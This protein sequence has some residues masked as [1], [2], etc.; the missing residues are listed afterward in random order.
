M[1]RLDIRVAAGHVHARRVGTLCADHEK[2]PPTVLHRAF[3]GSTH[4]HNRNWSKLSRGRTTKVR[5]SKMWRKQSLRIRA[6]RAA[7]HV[8]RGVE[9][10]L[11]RT[12]P[13]RSSLTAALRSA[14][15]QK[16]WL[17][18]PRIALRSSCSTAVYTLGVTNAERR[19]RLLGRRATDALGPRVRRLVHTL[20]RARRP[21]PCSV[22]TSL[23]GFS[24]QDVLRQ[25]PG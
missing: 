8:V 21:G 25:A 11:P 19:G 13:T 5:I 2:S 16:R 12:C 9:E 7:P 10:D 4:S 17:S 18:G 23:F 1:P 24:R 6:S 3:W 22:R 15:L 14:V 20:S